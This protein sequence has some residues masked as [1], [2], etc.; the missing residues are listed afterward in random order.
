MIGKNMLHYPPVGE[1]RDSLLRD[2][3]VMVRL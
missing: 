1:M 3:I 2:K